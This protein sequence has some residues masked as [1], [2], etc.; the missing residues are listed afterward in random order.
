MR[1]GPKRSL[2]LGHPA[3]HFDT[4]PAVALCRCASLTG[5]GGGSVRSTGMFFPDQAL[6]LRIWASRS[7]RSEPVGWE[8]RGTWV[9]IGLCRGATA[10]HEPDLTS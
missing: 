7:R 2:K 6:I 3:W 9:G 5:P 10:G 8:S 4:L 1:P